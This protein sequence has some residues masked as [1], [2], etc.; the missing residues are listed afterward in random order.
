MATV[1]MAT[2]TTVATQVLFVRL[3]P[4]VQKRCVNSLSL[5]LYAYIKYDFHTQ[6][7]KD[8]AEREM[9]INGAAVRASC[10]VC[11]VQPWERAFLLVMF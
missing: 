6:Q 3:D 7:N 2:A 9:V 5:S 4:F 11:A 8:T 10:C 1:A